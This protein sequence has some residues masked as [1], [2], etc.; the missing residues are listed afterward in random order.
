LERLSSAGQTIDLF[1]RVMTIPDSK[2][3]AG[4]RRLP[5]NSDAMLAYGILLERATKLGISSPEFYVFPACENLHIDGTRSQKTWRT[6]WRNVTRAAGL[7][8]L[9]FHDLRH[10][11]IT[12]LLEGGAPEAAVLSI[13]GH[14][15]WKMM[16]HYSHVRMDA[17]RKA[18]EGLSPVVVATEPTVGT[19]GPRLN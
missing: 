15:S 9:R 4:K 19:A 16:E 18:L 12:E 11:C 14:V 5:L 1:E 2:S 17:K 13:A 6:A 8:G 7:R 10:Q 3:E